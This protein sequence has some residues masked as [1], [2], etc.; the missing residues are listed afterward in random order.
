MFFDM[1]YAFSHSLGGFRAIRLN[2]TR[3]RVV[4]L[5]RKCVLAT[6]RRV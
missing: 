3:R 6:L 1:L 2:S 4:L 5:H